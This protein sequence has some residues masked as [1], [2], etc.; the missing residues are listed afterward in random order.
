MA[1]VDLTLTL[2]GQPSA[3]WAGDCGA[4]LESNPVARVLLTVHPAVMVAA[5][6][7]YLAA[8]TFFILRSRTDRSRS[9][10][11]VF[12]LGHTFG[13]STWLLRLPGGVAYCIAI[14]LIAR[15]LFASGDGVK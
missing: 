15:V 8:I 12:T 9:L 6:V 14:W 10:S 1:L 11:L 4:V 5:F 2:F 7:P 13:A 3:Y